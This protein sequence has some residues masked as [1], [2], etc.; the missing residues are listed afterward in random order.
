LRVFKDANYPAS[1]KVERT[2]K[3]PGEE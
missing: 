3:V 2:V 1:L